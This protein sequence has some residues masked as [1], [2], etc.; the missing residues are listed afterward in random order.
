[1]TLP[2]IAERANSASD[3]SFYRSVS[4]DSYY[5]I[6]VWLHVDDSSVN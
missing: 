6:S 2:M 5:D 1:M 3:S 4:S